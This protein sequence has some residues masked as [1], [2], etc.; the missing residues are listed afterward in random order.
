[1]EPLPTRRIESNASTDKQPISI[2]YGN[3]FTDSYG[4]PRRKDL[5]NR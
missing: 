1:M 3:T 5:P 4:L 2:H